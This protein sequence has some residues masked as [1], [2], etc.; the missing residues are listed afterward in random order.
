MWCIELVSSTPT[1]LPAVRE[2]VEE[3]LR[4]PDAWA[5]FD[6]PPRELPAR[7]ADELARL[8]QPAVPPGGDIAVAV[9]NRRGVFA[10]GLLVPHGD[11]EAEMKRI[12]VRPAHRGHGVGTAMT[13]ALVSV[14]R[15]LGYRSVA[16]DVMA[17]RRSAVH[18]YERVGFVPIVSYREHPTL[19]MRAYRLAI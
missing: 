12:Y 14:A 4:L 2:L 17:S 7:F 13:N 15:E 10:V 3:Y 11:A 1:H 9:D 5:R 6:G 16:L 8:P 19:E 18:L